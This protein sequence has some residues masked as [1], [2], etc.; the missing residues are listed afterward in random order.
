[1][2]KIKMFFAIMTLVGTVAAPAFAEG[3]GNGGPMQHSEGMVRGG[4]FGAWNSEMNDQNQNGEHASGSPAMFMRMRLAAVA[5][6]VS[7][8]SGT[9]ITVTA[10]K[11]DMRPEG[12]EGMHDR[13]M[14]NG[15]STFATTTPAT[16]TVYTI[17]AS[18]AKI[19]KG[20]A[21]TTIDT[22]AVGDM[23]YAQ[24]S[25]NASSTNS[26]I[27]KTVF[28]IV[29][30]QK[31]HDD[32]KNADLNGLLSSGQPIIVGTVATATPATASST[33]TSTPS[34]AILTVTSGSLTYTVDATNANVVIDNKASSSVSAIA[35]GDKVLVQG[36][37]S[38]TSVTATV[39]VD[40]NGQPKPAPKMDIGRFFGSIG[41]FFS[42][43]SHFF[44]F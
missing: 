41:S 36:T 30:P 32:G 8:V 34:A 16:S 19:F 7:N 21:T 10:V 37:V 3:Y 1:M 24:G 22:I 4:G 13:G 40:Q 33:A 15:S 31:K 38:G 20:N 26:I 18:S 27:A 11:N 43:F 28:D 35:V 29:P 5:G 39:I 23:V 14:M 2:N 17:D 12:P 44:G 6:T 42:R 25:W 9:T